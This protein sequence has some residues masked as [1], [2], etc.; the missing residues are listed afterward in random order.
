MPTLSTIL[1]F[2][3]A[4]MALLVVPGPAVVYIVTRAVTQGRTAGLL[5]VLGIHVGSIF[6]VIVTSLGMAALLV[7][8][9]TAF[10]IVKW[11][12]VAYLVWLGI[13]KLWLEKTDDGAVAEPPR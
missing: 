10:Q 12:G 2:I 3:A 1:L 8:S 9:E 13:R 5:S 4:T 6:Y 7:A 11:F